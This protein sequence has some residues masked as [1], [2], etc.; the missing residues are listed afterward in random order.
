MS[1]I[2]NISTTPFN[3]LVPTMVKPLQ[4]PSTGISSWVCKQISTHFLSR[5]AIGSSSSG[6]KKGTKTYVDEL[7]NDYLAKKTNVAASQVFFDSPEGH[8]LDGVKIFNLQEQRKTPA[9]QKWLVYVL[10]SKAIWQTLF[11]EN[12]PVTTDPSRTPKRVQKKKTH[13]IELAERTGRNVLCVN[14]RGTGG[15]TGVRPSSFTHL[16]NDV[17]CGINSLE[18]AKLENIMLWGRSIGGFPASM[19]SSIT[20]CPLILQNTADTFIALGKPHSI[21]LINDIKKNFINNLERQKAG[22]RRL[23][24]LATD[25]FLSLPH[26][27]FRVTYFFFRMLENIVRLNPESLTDLKEIAKTICIDTILTITALTGLI[28]FPFSRPIDQFNAKLKQLYKDRLALA[29][30]VES[31]KFIWCAERI[32]TCSGWEQSNA[33]LVD[34]MDPNKVFIVQV[35]HDQTIHKPANLSTG[36]EK[37]GSTK[38]RINKFDV[39]NPETESKENPI[40][41]PHEA[42][43]SPIHTDCPLYES[44]NGF[45]RSH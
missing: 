4:N 11:E 36:L 3:G 35:Y 37:I 41:D 10:P 22:K 32:L 45:M 14:Y 30:I 16:T 19:V 33:E 24:F 26:L 39:T 38:H 5:Y 23:T 17:I 20:G 1:A 44:L 9:E 15:S 31:D 18:G 21:R 2:P 7:N 25:A 29:C 42:M 40:E 13:L 28:T 34:K 27:A 12:P 8:K 6:F 43:A